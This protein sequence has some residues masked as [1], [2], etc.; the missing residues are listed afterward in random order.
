LA[1]R[2]M[3]VRLDC[4]ELEGAHVDPRD[5]PLVWEYWSTG[6]DGWMPL[7]MLDPSAT[8]RVR[9]AG[10][11]DPTYGLNRSGEVY[12]NIGSDSQ[13]QV[14]DGIDATWVRIRYVD[15]EGQGYTTSPRVQGIRSE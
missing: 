7:T 13:V 6:A 12:F 3:L 15:K 10:D 2:S 8:G 5:P 1:G 11:I 4:Q 14:F 9:E